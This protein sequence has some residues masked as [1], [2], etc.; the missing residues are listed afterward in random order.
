LSALKRFSA[1][2]F[3]ACAPLNSGALLSWAAH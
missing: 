1:D 2:R 3:K